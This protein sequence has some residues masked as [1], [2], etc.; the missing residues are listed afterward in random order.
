MDG[1]GIKKRELPSGLS[2]FPGALHHET[3]ESAGAMD[4]TDVYMLNGLYAAQE[5]LLK[6]G[7][8]VCEVLPINFNYQNIRVVRTECLD[9][10][11]STVVVQTSGCDCGNGPTVR[12]GVVEARRDWNDSWIKASLASG[13]VGP[14]GAGRCALLASQDCLPEVLVVRRPGAEERNRI[15]SSLETPS[16]RVRDVLFWGD[17]S[18]GY[19]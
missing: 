10:D 11:G 13:P 16:M 15:L 19:S 14:L 12:A 2:G 6:N 3:A 8:A 17:F 9:I 4:G 1:G 18:E 7:E 5:A